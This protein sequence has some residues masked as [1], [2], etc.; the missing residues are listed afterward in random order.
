[1]IEGNYAGVAADVSFSASGQLN[2]DVIKQGWE[3]ISP[4]LGAF[5][6]M[7]A[8]SFTAGG[9]AA[10]VEIIC[11]FENRDLLLKYIYNAKSE[12]SGVWMTYIPQKAQAENTAAYTERI[13]SVGRKIIGIPCT[14]LIHP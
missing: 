11:H 13:V 14:G 8:I 7:G 6:S 10:L 9:S 5:E 3:G 4:S 1:M 2:A 12:L